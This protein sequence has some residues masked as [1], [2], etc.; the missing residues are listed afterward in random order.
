VALELRPGRLVRLWQDEL[1]PFPPYRLDS[2]ALFVAY[3]NSAEYGFHRAK[4]WGEPAR[5]FDGYIEFRHAVNDG[6]AKAEDRGEGFH[7]LGGALRYFC[8]D[9]IDVAHK[10]D[11]RDRILQGPPFDEQERREIIDYCTDD[12][13]AL[14]RLFPHLIQTI[15]PPFEHAMLRA[16]YQWPIAQMEGR[17][18]PADGTGLGRLRHRWQDLRLALVEELDQPFGCFEVVNGKAHWRKAR[19]PIW[20][21][22]IG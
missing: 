22:G 2:D 4:G 17:G 8:E 16:K 6:S 15:R 12:V 9:E 11:M 10:K 18:V 19:S 13:R 20:C 14:A 3:V 7:S 21:A 5:A 1:G